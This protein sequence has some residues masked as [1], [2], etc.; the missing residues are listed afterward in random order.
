MNEN[1]VASFFLYFTYWHLSNVF[2]AASVLLN[3]TRPECG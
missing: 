3:L 1:D 2:T